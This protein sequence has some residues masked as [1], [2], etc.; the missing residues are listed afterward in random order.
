MTNLPI[1]PKR[2]KGALSITLNCQEKVI[3]R[4]LVS[5]RIMELEPD[6]KSNKCYRRELSF[7]RSV[8]RK[9]DARCGHCG[10]LLPKEVRK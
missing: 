5:S 8:A 7:L 4:Q 9:I 10:Q 2:S 6:E 1:T 3:L